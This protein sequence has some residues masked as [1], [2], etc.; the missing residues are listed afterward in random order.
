MTL[1]LLEAMA[2]ERDDL[3]NYVNL[4]GYNPKFG[5]PRPKIGSVTYRPQPYGQGKA[6]YEL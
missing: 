3:I 5:A 2:A 1:E 4:F 6:L